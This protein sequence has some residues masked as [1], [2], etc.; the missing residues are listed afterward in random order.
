MTETAN[1]RMERIEKL[2]RELEYEV[3]RGTIA[4]NMR[5]FDQLP[6]RV[7]RAMWETQKDYDC[8]ILAE[9]IEN[10][11]VPEGVIVEHILE[12]SPEPLVNRRPGKRRRL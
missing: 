3:T 8:R 11:E 5:A 1:I 9:Q 7:R 6:A 10:C 12:T 4:A 2:L